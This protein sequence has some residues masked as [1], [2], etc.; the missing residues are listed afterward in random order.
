MLQMVGLRELVFARNNDESPQ[1][2]PSSDGESIMNDNNV[3]GQTTSR[4]SSNGVNENMSMNA[5]RPICTINLQ[6]QIVG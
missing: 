6:L 2:T 5:D 1:R 3:N 4:S